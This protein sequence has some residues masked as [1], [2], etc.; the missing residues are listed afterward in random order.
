MSRDERRGR[1]ARLA[2]PTRRAERVHAGGGAILGEDAA[3]KAPRVLV[4]EFAA[5]AAAAASLPGGIIAIARMTAVASATAAHDVPSTVRSSA[6][7]PFRL[8]RIVT[9]QRSPCSMRTSASSGSTPP[10]PALFSAASRT[11][12]RVG[13]PAGAH[14]SRR[15]SS[16]AARFAT[17]TA[18]RATAREMARMAPGND[19]AT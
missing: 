10:L 17:S 11:C 15:R 5:A 6:A 16:A 14:Q 12:S 3:G 2:R 1:G 9:L 18:T 13:H 19:R 7:V 4:E 8:L